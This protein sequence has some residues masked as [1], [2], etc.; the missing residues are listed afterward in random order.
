M[1]MLSWVLCMVVSRKLIVL[2]CS[3]SAVNFR[4]GCKL[5]KSVRIDCMFVWSVSKIMRMSSTYLN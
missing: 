4:L 3:S 5:L 1:F 2:L